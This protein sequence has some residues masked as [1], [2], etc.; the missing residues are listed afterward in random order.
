MKNELLARQLIAG[1]IICMI[2][3]AL[4]SY[5]LPATLAAYMF[6]G[7]SRVSAVEAV[8]M[9]WLEG[10]DSTISIKKAI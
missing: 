1:A 8:E 4:L 9:Q 5:L 3:L 7:L 2:V 6:P 10:Q